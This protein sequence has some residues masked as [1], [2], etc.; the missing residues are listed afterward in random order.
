MKIRLQISGIVLAT[1]ALCISVRAF[2]ADGFF[3]GPRFFYSLLQGGTADE[4]NYKVPDCTALSDQAYKKL[5]RGCKTE[6]ESSRR[7]PT[8]KTVTLQHSAPAAETP[9]ATPVAE[10]MK[11]AQKVDDTTKTFRLDYIVYVSKKDCEAGRKSLGA[12]K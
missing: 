7:C 1:A 5:R 4:W 8:E 12:S 10:V 2:A 11:D 6:G 3:G 9:G